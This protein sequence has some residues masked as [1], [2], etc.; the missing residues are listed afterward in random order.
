MGTHQPAPVSISRRAMRSM[1]AGLS[2][3]IKTNCSLERIAMTELEQAQNATAPR[4]WRASDGW[5]PARRWRE[6][7]FMRTRNGFS[8]YDN[9]GAARTPLFRF[10]RLAHGLKRT[11]DRIVEI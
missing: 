2:S 4:S 10:K 3:G 7:F 11:Y 6:R 5:H 9:Q 8:G 1:R